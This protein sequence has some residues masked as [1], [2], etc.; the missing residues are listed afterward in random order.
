MNENL[1]SNVRAYAAERQLLIAEPL[2]S[3][4]DGIVLVGKSQTAPA[5][6]ALKAHRFPESYLRETAVYRRLREKA[7]NSVLGF[8][9]PELKIKK[10]LAAFEELGIYLLDVSPA[11]IAF[12]D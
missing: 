9:V 10:I 1:T 11:N 5:R 3:G 2:G 7:I 8:N 6:V 12:H 4:K